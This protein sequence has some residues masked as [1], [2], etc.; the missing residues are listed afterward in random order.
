MIVS[1]N[2]LKKFVDITMPV[3]ELVTLIGERLVEVEGTID[4]ADKYKDVIVA[5]VVSA[6]KMENSDHLSL[7]FIDDGGAVQGVDRTD[8][9]MVQIVCGAPNVTAGM[10][11]A[12]LPPNSVV[13]ETYGTDDPFTLSARP[14]RGFVSNGMIASARELDLYDEHDGILAIDK[15]AESGASFADLYDL[16]DTLIDIENKSLTHR[17]DA[18][19]LIGL[20]REIAGIQGIQFKTPE[21][22]SDVDGSI[23]GSGAIDSPRIEIEDAALSGRFQL[24]AIGGV[25][26][27]VTS[28][29][30]LQSYLSRSGVRPINALVD[31]SNY[32]MLLTGQ[33]THM[34][35]YDKLRAVAADDF[36][37]RVRTARAG[38]VLKL[39][40]GKDVALDESDIVIAA[41]DT[42]VGLAGIMGGASTA[43]DTSTRTVLLEVAT[44]DLYRMRSS[45]MRHGIFSEAVTR[46]TKGVPVELGRPVLLEAVRMVRECTVGAIVGDI[47]DE[48]PSEQSPVQIDIASSRVN[49]LLGTQFSSGDIAAVLG[50]VE[51]GVTYEDDELSITVPYWRN[52]IHIQEDVIEEVGRLSGFDTIH[53]AMPRRD[54]TAVSPS[55]FDT[56]RNTLRM[57]IARAGL[58]EALTYSFVH[59]DLLKKAGQSVDNSY[60]ITNSISPDLQYYRQSLTPSLVQHVNPNVRLGF[61]S[62]GIFEFNKVHE[63][64]DGL[65]VEEV[66][67][68]KNV[69]AAV[70]TD[71]KNADGTAYYQA[72]YI[73]EYALKSI[74]V[75]VVLTPVMDSDQPISAQVSIFE[76]KRSAYVYTTTGVFLGIVGEYK[77]SASTAFKLPAF[78]AGFEVSVDALFE[79]VPLVPIEYK[80]SS[81]YPSVERDISLKVDGSVVYADIH[82]AVMAALSRI[83]LEVSM[84]PLDIYKPQGGETKN[85][86]FRMTFVSHDRTLTSDEV[87]EAMRIVSEYVVNEVNAEVV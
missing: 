80:S 40:D 61:E 24:V 51:F 85:V 46:Y 50:N 38:E 63:K 31:I 54:F 39:L 70:V 56:V 15:Q 12:W 19:G 78:T 66:P 26:E 14:L 6:E 64:A 86:T 7:V 2:W 11:I 34:Y 77:R 23:E 49:G 37:V 41:G 18:F 57:A 10:L 72:K 35:D 4:L 43:T 69:L 84:A 44:F 71:A 9:G 45:Q 76:P 13:P 68:E 58:N 33:P 52:D 16:N 81:R 79:E 59:G 74:G 82:T 3:D 21:W 36:T 75:E 65:T 22:L 62:F 28:S 17:P 29:V 47:V 87:N 42:A 30:Q 53:T 5:R 1:V 83:S 73:L 27:G 55:R 20:A 32:L 25:S 48:Y 8:E 67:V 60:R